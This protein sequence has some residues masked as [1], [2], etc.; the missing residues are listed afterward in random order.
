VKIADVPI[1]VI[2]DF[3]RR[4]RHRMVIDRRVDAG[5]RSGKRRGAVPALNQILP[6]FLRGI[7][8]RKQAAQPHDRNI[9]HYQPL[10]N[11]SLLPG[12]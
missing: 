5:F 9:F 1:A 7:R 11:I 8:P 10:L 6:V 3:I 12:A 4:T 2:A